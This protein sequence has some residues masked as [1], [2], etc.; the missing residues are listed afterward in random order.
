MI[1][2]NVMEENLYQ[3]LSIHVLFDS[4]VGSMLGEPQ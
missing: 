2:E 1:L 3:S 4:K